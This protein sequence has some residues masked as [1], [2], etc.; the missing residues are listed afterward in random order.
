MVELN[1][2][3][4]EQK[5]DLSCSFRLDQVSGNDCVEIKLEVLLY[6]GRFVEPENANLR[7]SLSIVVLLFKIACF[8]RKKLIKF[9]IEK[10][11]DLN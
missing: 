9:S 5:V 4:I 8:V 3:I 11:A 1:S 6:R 2:K 10:A 7:G